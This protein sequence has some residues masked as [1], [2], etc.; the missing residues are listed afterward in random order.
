[1]F[2]CLGHELGMDVLVE[3]HT[4]EDLEKALKTE[5]NIIGINNRNLT[6]FKV[7]IETTQRLI[8]QIPKDKIKVSESGINTSDQVLFLK[9]LGVNAV[10]IGEAFMKSDD[11]QAKMRELMQG[12]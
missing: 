6:T 8:S 4:E 3:V 9:S 1:G 11:I 10:L 5:A 12:L 2:L 7:D